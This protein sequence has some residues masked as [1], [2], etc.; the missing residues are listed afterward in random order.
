MPRKSQTVEEVIHDLRKQN[1]GAD[2]DPKKYRKV[3]ESIRAFRTAAPAKEPAKK[4]TAP[5]SAPPPKEYSLDDLVV[6]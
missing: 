4:K 2:L 5:K 6:E 1:Y 3:I